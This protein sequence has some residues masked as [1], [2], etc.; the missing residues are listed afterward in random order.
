[1]NLM[2]WSEHFVSGID[3]VDTQH[4]ALVDMINAAAPHLATGGE[5]SQRIVGPLLDKLV[6]YAA[7]HFKFEETLMQQI[8]L[9]PEYFAQHRNSHEAFVTEVVQMR[10]QYERGETLSGN[11]LLHF[12]T[13]WLTF[14]ILSEDKHMARQILAVQSGQTPAQAFDALDTSVGAPQA[15]YNAALIDLFSLLTARNHTLS[16]ANAQVR[17]AKRELEAMNSMLETR[18]IERTQELAEANTALQA[19]RASLV[20]SIA[21]LRLT[22][23]QLLQSEKMAAVGQLAA[24]VAHEINNPIGFVSSNLVSLRGYV[25]NMLTLL[26]AYEKTRE[27][28]PPGLRATIESLPAHAELAYMREDVPELLQEC[29]AGLDRVKLIV[30]DLRDFT[31][32]DNATWSAADL[33][34]AL[35]SAL[36]VA[37]NEIKYKAEV[38]KELTPL[39]TVT[40][41][42]AQLCQVFVNLLV[43]AAQ[44]IENHGTITL[45]SGESGDHVW[46]EICDTGG[47][48]SAETQKRIF[49]PFYTTKPVGQGT[50]LGLSISWDIIARHHGRVEVHSAV[51]QGTR[52]RIILPIAQSPM[53]SLS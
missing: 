4:K 13:S 15:V 50:G 35:E 36:N 40:C 16:V 20:D 31:H 37:G 34:T 43:N 8:E 29:K 23:E 9:L 49:E 6:A 28:M 11:D 33:N 44:A 19:E 18:V 39:P 53:L 45:R 3:A 30:N 46:F 51:G 42:P 14:H 24:G 38:V 1:M 12:L 41:I 48:M 7:S 47:G 32:V 17:D 52:F 21:R 5:S 10:A 27:R 22:Q 25:E 2:A 26:G